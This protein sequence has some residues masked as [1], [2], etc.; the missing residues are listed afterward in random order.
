MAVISRG[1]SVMGSV[2]RGHQPPSTDP[3][4]PARD[5]VV[6]RH[7][8]PVVGLVVG[9]GWFKVISAFPP[10]AGR[11]GPRGAPRATPART[12]AL[13]APSVVLTLHP[14]ILFPDFR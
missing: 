12:P 1:N 2:D 13:N 4:A 10:P 6:N 14:K 7:P 9:L 3:C 5:F 8:G 11:A